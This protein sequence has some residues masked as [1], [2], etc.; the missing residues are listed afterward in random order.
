MSVGWKSLSAAQTPVIQTRVLL[1]N[2]RSRAK[3]C[4]FDE[5]M[6]APGP[7]IQR[8]SYASYRRGRRHLKTP[9]GAKRGRR[10]MGVKFALNWPPRSVE[11]PVPPEWRHRLEAKRPTRCRFRR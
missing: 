10:H 4:V 1:A 6:G 7:W 9:K 3:A 11:K 8:L 2:C 5:M